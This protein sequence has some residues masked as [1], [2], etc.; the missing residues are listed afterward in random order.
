M[1][2][3]SLFSGDAEL[4][5]ADLTAVGVGGAEP[6]LYTGAVHE[7]HAP[8]AATRCQKALFVLTIMANTAEHT[9]AAGHASSTQSEW[10]GIHETDVL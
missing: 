10:G 2:E 3:R 5:A 6:P 9:T 1:R 4:E 8:G 7:A